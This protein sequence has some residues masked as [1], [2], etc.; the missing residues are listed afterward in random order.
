MSATEL[1]EELQDRGESAVPDG[2]KG[3]T[4]RSEIEMRFKGQRPTPAHRRIAQCLID[5]SG[6]IGFL[7]SMELATLAN[8]SQP[9]VSRFA[10]ALGFDGFLDMRRCFRALSGA[11]QDVSDPA[12]N[13]YQTAA[14]T[15]AANITDLVAGLADTS[16]IRAFGALLASSRPLIVL[17]LRASA[18]I[19]E[20]FGYFASKVHSDVRVM[21]SGG[22]LIEDQ[23]EQAVAAGATSVLAFL[24][25]LYPKETIKALQYARQLGLKVALVT[26]PAFANHQEYSDLLLTV[27]IHS[28]LVFDSSA[29]LAVMSSIILDA[30]CDAM[31]EQAEQRL[32]KAD[33]SSARRKVFVQ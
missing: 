23:M 13:R 5:H 31:P 10:V 14:Q 9:S 12:L 1:S 16:T 29:A 26:D 32:E 28:G 4:L 11:A 7:S 25:P 24:M 22:S 33:Q 2:P 3:V 6:E 30:M 21:V 15:E 18:G 17:G 20:H 27:R 8:V 19:A